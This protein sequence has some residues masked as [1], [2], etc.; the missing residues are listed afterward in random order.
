M[1]HSLVGRTVATIL[2]VLLG[3]LVT[4]LG[5]SNY[6]IKNQQDAA[7]EQQ[8]MLFSEFASAQINTGTR[9][10]RAAMIKPQ[11][12]AMMASE[13]LH[14]AAIRV[15]H[16]SGKEILTQLADGTSG[17]LAGYFAEPN[18]ENPGEIHHEGDYFLTRTLIEL[19]A[20]DARQ[21]VGEL[22]IV[23]DP[24]ANEAQIAQ[25]KL[26]LAGL[27][28]V[29]IV[30]TGLATVASMRRLLS[31]PIA[32]IVEA[33]EDLASGKEDVTL[34][35]ANT[36]EISKIVSTLDVFR[37]NLIATRLM[38]ERE[39]QSREQEVRDLQ[40]TKRFQSNLVEVMTPAQQGDFSL[41]LDAHESVQHAEMAGV[42]N[43]MLD[44][45]QNGLQETR[46]FL[47]ALAS[48]YLDRTMAGDH[49]GEF[50]HLARDATT[51]IEALNDLIA[52]IRAASHRNRQASDEINDVSN[53]LSDRAT[54]QALSLKNTIEAMDAISATVTSNAKKIEAAETLSKDVAVKALEGHRA[55]Q[56]AVGAVARIEQSSAGITEV[57]SV[58]QSIA[59][60]TNLLALN[61]SV[62]AARAGDAGKGFAVVANEVRNL[63]QRSADAVTDI[64]A[65]VKAS[66]DDV[67]TGVDLVGATGKVLEDM[68]EALSKLA[69]TVVDV[70]EA[71]RQQAATV[72]DINGTINDMGQQT[73][74]NTKLASRTA[75]IAA[76][77]QEGTRSLDTSLARF[78]IKSDRHHASRIPALA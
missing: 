19:G 25:F 13:G 48:A 63:A 74:E 9:L 51:A 35:K 62:E 17:S 50:A 78:K 67:Q 18:F 55:A 64:S 72:Q 49:R 36:R 4:L 52:D 39:Q 70:A 56:D 1:W 7:F 14:I 61:A 32:S 59:S 75:A 5:V 47:A 53:D 45:V 71:G 28:L 11:I 8:S 41:R 3:C 21:T 58:I 44:T 60:Q 6:L 10:K 65:L 76:E 68:D 69:Q 2:M 15:V 34:P 20:G 66:I 29:S 40:E 16:T 27:F 30:V 54:K 23:W 26:V 73:Q 38:K 24:S 22:A 57:I 12:D 37:D 46:Q 42:I 43:G 33:M 77:I 31:R